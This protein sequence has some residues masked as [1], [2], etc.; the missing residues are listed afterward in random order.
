[1][2]QNSCRA[3]KASSVGDCENYC[4]SDDRRFKLTMIEKFGWEK[5]WETLMK[6]FD[7]KLIER[8]SFSALM[9]LP[10]ANSEPSVLS[11]LRKSVQYGSIWMFSR[12]LVLEIKDIYD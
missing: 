3:S 10:N 2:D 11:K 7:E 8:S 12:K 5:R 6:G 9:G 4:F 1:M